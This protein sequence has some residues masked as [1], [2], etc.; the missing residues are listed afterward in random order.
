MKINFRKKLPMLLILL[1]IQLFASNFVRSQEEIPIIS[2][3][4]LISV[5]G[6][7]ES[8]YGETVTGIGDYNLDGYEDFIVGGRMWQDWRGKAWIY[9]GSETGINQTY[10]NFAIWG[11]ENIAD[12]GICF[13]H[14][15]VK[16][17]DINQ[18]G[19]DDF[20]V[21]GPGSWGGWDVGKVYFFYGN[22]SKFPRDLD[23]TPTT[24]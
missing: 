19:V 6:E 4:D 16:V 5:T 3:R 2:A 9:F 14:T 1:T 23:V 22:S 15:T 20:A 13:G 24:V 21:G 12:S 18:D 8:V 17:G 7:V 10:A 11:E